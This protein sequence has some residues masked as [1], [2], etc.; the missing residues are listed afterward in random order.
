MNLVADEGVDKAIVDALRAGGFSVKYFA[1]VGAGATDKD[2]LAA[3]SDAQSLLLTCDKDFGELVFRQRQTHA[4][5]ILIR[6]TGLPTASKANI[7]LEAIKQHG[8]DMAGAFTVISPGL[9]RVRHPDPQP[10]KR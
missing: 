2:V 7:V 10:S 8:S 5:V 1:E 4:G 6:L 3:A 9:L